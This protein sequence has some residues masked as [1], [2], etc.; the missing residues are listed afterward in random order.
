MFNSRTLYTRTWACVTAAA[1]LT[2]AFFLADV[3]L[4]SQA[5]EKAA[6]QQSAA[7]ETHPIHASDASISTYGLDPARKTDW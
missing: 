4:S 5:T 7:I 2:C 6:S 1:V 3:K